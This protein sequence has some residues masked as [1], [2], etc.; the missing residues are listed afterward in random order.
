MT[1][2]HNNPNSDGERRYNRR[3]KATR[4]TIE[5]A[6]GILKEKFPWLNHLRVNPKFAADIVICWPTLCSIAREGEAEEANPVPQLD[7]PEEY[8]ILDIIIEVPRL[9]AIRLQQEIIRSMM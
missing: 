1:P 4:Q 9:N 3:L 8:N 7:L 5:C 2:L 6:Y